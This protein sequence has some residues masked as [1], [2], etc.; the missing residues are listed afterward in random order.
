MGFWKILGLQ[1]TSIKVPKVISGTR[2]IPER[3]LWVK[4]GQKKIHFVLFGDLTSGSLK[5]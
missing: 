4:K 5:Y 1:L 2:T 3:D